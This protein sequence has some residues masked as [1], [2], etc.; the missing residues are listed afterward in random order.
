MNK[1][2]GSTV[3]LSGAI[4]SVPDNGY[5]WRDDITSFLQSIEIGVINPLKKPIIN[6]RYKEGPNLVEKIR[7]LKE[8]AE[9][10]ESREI[11]KN[12][13]RADLHL[14]DISNFTIVYLD[15]D[16]H[17]C[18]TYSEV[19]YSALERKPTLIVCKQGKQNVP[20][21]L[22]GLCPH[23]LF[24]NSWNELKNYIKHVAFDNINNINDLNG[25]W[26]FLDYP[27]I[28]GDDLDRTGP[29]YFKEGVS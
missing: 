6:D 21:W 14:L 11:M 8:Q 27:R 26:K 25:R 20:N 24:F 10:N 9:Y 12:V 7:K 29:Q 16:Y 4:D 1:L 23:E 5:G 2:A 13:V 17:H 18:G 3:Y 22:F 19:T 15:M 28:F